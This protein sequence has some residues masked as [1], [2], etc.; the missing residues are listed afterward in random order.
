[1]EV[2][3]ADASHSA[4]PPAPLGKTRG[5]WR[6]RSSHHISHE[7]P[8]LR[9]PLPSPH[10]CKHRK[11]Q[12]VWSHKLAVISSRTYIS[13]NARPTLSFNTLPTMTTSTTAPHFW[14]RAE[15]KKNERR[16]ALTPDVC[17]KLIRDHS[18]AITV[19]KS[20]DRI[21]DI[22]EYERIGCKIA[23]TGS[24]QTSAPADA[25]IVGL[26]ELPETDT[27]PLSHTHI[28]FAHCFKNQRDWE[29]V[30]SRF[31]R[32]HG[33]LLDLEFLN[34]PK[35]GRRVAAFG[36]YAGYA[37]AAL[38]LDV[39]AHR[40]LEGAD[41]PYP[42]VKPFENDDALITHIK[43]RVQ[44]AVKKNGGQTPSVMVMGALGRCGSGAVDLARKIGISDEAIIKW[45]INETKAGGPFKEIVAHDVFVNCI[46]LSKPIPPFLNREVIE[47][48][49]E[50]ERK[51]QVL[52]DVS[53]D[54]TNPHNPIPLYD[55][56]TTFDDPVLTVEF[57]KPHPPLSVITIDHLPTLVPREASEMF[58]TDLLPSL[59][60]LKTDR[61]APVWADAE[62]LF[63]EK[64]ADARKE[65]A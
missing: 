63:K 42:T 21:F 41:T 34:D 2:T 31:D 54:T 11:E 29:K 18:F 52:V 8:L 35:T 46:Y 47:A 60:L 48:V 1:M 53:C 64:L 22:A 7:E 45:D 27:S 6:A 28:M 51:L 44:Q 30:L 49:S 56:S 61:N 24:W 14:L 37:G 32:G 43:G 5:R 40:Q 19:E 50:K 15:T 3:H 25:Y 17:N 65:L 9:R 39:W 20:T 62:K 12:A 55:Q 57:A 23:E 16:T 13:Q 59:L 26:K 33:T 38:G 36:Y 10:G 58:A 4:P